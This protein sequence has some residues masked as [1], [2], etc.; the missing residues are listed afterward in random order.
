MMK[1]VA[2]LGSATLLALGA[3]PAFAQFRAALDVADA[4]V[5]EGAASQQRIEELDDQ[6]SEALGEYR[7][8]VKQ[9]ELTERYNVSRERQV[10]NQQ[11][12][13]QSFQRDLQNV[14]GIKRAVTPLMEEMVANLEQLVA[15][16]IPFLP[17]ERQNR[18]E[19]L[20]RIMSDSSQNEASRYGLILEAFQIEADYGRSV[21]VYDGSIDVDG[22]E[23][24]GEFLRIGR[25]ALIFKT[26]D[27]SIL[28]IYDSEARQFVELPDSYLGDVRLA[29][30]IGKE[31]AAP[32]LIEIPVKAPVDMTGGQ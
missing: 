13:I 5:R 17:T 15:A 16:D 10:E 31:Q 11:E 9:L 14:E 18:I 27:D 4:T 7:A 32:N 12:D 29:T 21:D 19:R 3:T 8:N 23:V 22:Q 1:K 2:L 25:V 26:A 20:R 6:A 24:Q 28:R 30:R